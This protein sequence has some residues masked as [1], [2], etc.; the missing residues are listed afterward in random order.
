MLKI[1]IGSDESLKGDTFGGIVVAAVLADEEQKKKLSAIGVMDSKKVQNH[2]IPRLAA[3]I[4]T[5]CPYTTFKSVLPQ[6]YNLF[7][8]TDLLNQLHHECATR[9]KDKHFADMDLSHDQEEENF[10][11]PFLLPLSSVYRLYS[12]FASSEIK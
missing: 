11:N 6:E 10:V 1:S 4:R 3:H 5:I 12:P 9:L 2:H 7:K 8:Q